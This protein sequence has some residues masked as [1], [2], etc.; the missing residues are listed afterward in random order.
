MP[1]EFVDNNAVIDHAARRRIRSH[2]AKGKNVGKTIVRTSRQKAFG[3]KANSTREL[4]RIPKASE[5]EADSESWDRAVDEIE[6]Q[7]GD[8]LSAFSF[9]VQIGPE[10]R[11]LVLRGRS[12]YRS[13]AREKMALI[14]PNKSSLFLPEWTAVCA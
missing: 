1:F 8:G 10:S 2:V 4:V 9:P 14:R 6:R 7:L 11:S 5:D 13:Q 12:C 3:S